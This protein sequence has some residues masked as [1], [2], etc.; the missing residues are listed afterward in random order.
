[1]KGYST[2]MVDSNEHGDA[3]HNTGPFALAVTAWCFAKTF[4]KNWI[5]K[6]NT[7]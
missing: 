5:Q 3:A 2:S 1:M 4:V 6:S 7:C